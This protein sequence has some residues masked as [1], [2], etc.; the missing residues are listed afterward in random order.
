[1]VGD[2]R[3]G[4]HLGEPGIDGRVI[5][6]CIFKKWNGEE[7]TGLNWLRIGTCGGLLLMQK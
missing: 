1:L 2:L 3:E 5:L 4:N 7:W 6:K